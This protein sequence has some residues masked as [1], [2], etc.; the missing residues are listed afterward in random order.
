MTFLEWNDKLAEH[1]FRPD[2][3]GREVYLFVTEDLLN[4]LVQGFA[5]AV[6]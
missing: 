3:S 2:M 1:F 6:D 4:E 5:T